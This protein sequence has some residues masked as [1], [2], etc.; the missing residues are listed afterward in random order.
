MFLLVIELFSKKILKKYL[1]IY[2]TLNFLVIIALF[3]YYIDNGRDKGWRKVGLQLW[4]CETQSLFLCSYL[5]IIVLF[6][7]RTTVNLLEPHSVC[8]IH[9]FIV[10]N[11]MWLCDN[12][13]HFEK[14]SVEFIT[15]SKPGLQSLHSIL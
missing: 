10:W 13:G 12:R 9:D 15:L 3:T 7:I 4:V 14:A 2:F 6:S 11:L 5:L 1:K 8:N